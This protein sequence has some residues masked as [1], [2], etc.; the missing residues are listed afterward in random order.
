MAD[1]NLNPMPLL[2]RLRRRRPLVM[3]VV[4]L[5][6]FVSTA[7]VAVAL[8][9]ASGTGNG[10][11]KALT[12]Q[13]LTVTAAST[14]TADLFPG[15]SGDLQFTVTN[16]NPYPISLTAVDYGAVTSSDQANCPA[17]NLTTA[18]DGNLASP[19][20]LN[21]NAVNTPATIADAITLDT[22]APDGCQGVTFTVAIT[23]TGAQV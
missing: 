19:I 8:W 10:G 21:A 9:S 22:N 17:A 2:E 6:T 16:P 12:A 20:A 23:L 3:V 18:A 1:P 7:G 15:A 5:I 4:G 14:P 11:A 13:A